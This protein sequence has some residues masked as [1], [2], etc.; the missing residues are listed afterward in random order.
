MLCCCTTSSNDQ[1]IEPLA[2]IPP[3]H[4]SSVSG[5]QLRVREEALQRCGKVLKMLPR[6]QTQCADIR[7]QHLSYTFS[8]TGEQLPYALYVPPGYEASKPAPLVVQLHGLTGTY[9]RTIALAVGASGRNLV[10]DASIRTGAILLCPLGYHRASW[11]G[12]R[13]RPV[14][15]PMARFLDRDLTLE[16]QLGE[17]DVLEAIEQVRAAYNIDEARISLWGHSMGGAGTMHL[18]IKHPAKFAAI[19]LVAPALPTVRTSGAFVY[20][21]EDLARIRSLPVMAIN[22]RRDRLTPAANAQLWA[23]RMASLGMTHEYIESDDTHESV[24]KNDD[25]M[26]RLFEFLTRER[27]GS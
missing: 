18:A 25:N 17:Q 9:D 2:P 7:V 13:R 23:M 1:L 22:G 12:A 27:G 16:G 24:V 11:Y 6:F 26:A 19:G 3:S 10:I 5:D 21:I 8:V 20:S 15:L 14:L 4:Q